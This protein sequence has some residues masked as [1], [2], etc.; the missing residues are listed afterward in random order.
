MHFIVTTGLKPNYDLIL[1]GQAIAKELNAPFVHRENRSIPDLKAAYQVEL[2]L[3]TTKKGL[4]AN[5]PEGELFFHLNMAQLRIKNLLAGKP[6][7]M[8]EAMGL[9]EGMSVLD[10]TL[11]LGADALV[12]SFITGAGG[13]VVGLESSPI[14]AIIVRE[15]LRRFQVKDSRLTAALRRI[16]VIG[17][18]YQD[19][20][21]KQQDDSFDVVYFDPMFRRPIKES[22]HLK[23]MRFV[24]DHRAIP[25]A[26]LEDA[27]RVARQCVVIKETN[28]SSEFVRLNIPRI[29]GGKYSSVQYGVI[30]VN[31]KR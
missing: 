19:Y 14:T 4:I 18:D 20:L 17:T 21:A 11:G 8:I 29:A 25:F 24:A 1:A 26:V 27:K 3:L 28:H 12:S 9:K 2:I 10:C 23:P 31:E 16:S 13:L 15:G 7:H 30:D 6:D 5:M 22:I